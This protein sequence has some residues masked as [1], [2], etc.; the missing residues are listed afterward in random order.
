MTHVTIQRF[1]EAPIPTQYGLLRTVVFREETPEGA[2]ENLALVFGEIDGASEVLT[3]VH[4]ECLTGEVMRSLKCDCGEQLDVALRSIAEAGRG[5]VLYLRQEGRG[6]GLGNKIRAYAL[7]E[8]RGLDT[9]EANRAL[10]F[11]DDLRDYSVAARMLESLGVRSI[12]LMTNN[13]AKADVLARENINIVRRV[14]MV[15]TTNLH[16]RNYLRTKNRRM[17]HVIPEETKIATQIFCRQPSLDE[18]AALASIGATHLAWC[19]EPND[20]ASLQLSFQIIEQVRAAR[21]VSTIMIMSSDVETIV[22]ITRM[23]QPNL[24][25]IPAE[26]IGRGIV[27]NDLPRLADRLAPQTRLMM[28]IPVRLAGSLTNIDS[29]AIAARYQHFADCLILDTA[30]D[31]DGESCGCTGKTNDWDLCRE[32]VESSRIPVMLAGGL[33]PDNVAAAMHSVRPWGVDACSSLETSPGGS[34]DLV[35]SQQFIQRANEA[36][37][38]IAKIDIRSPEPLPS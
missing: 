10:G 3:R 7:Q 1:T 13:P 14:P 36:H 8:S 24:I 20:A 19:V 33:S 25:L 4:S 9:V 27:E 35:A 32:I 17:G 22:P 16:N 29:R 2:R 26:R 21:V 30:L 28:S 38:T 18:M 31:P 6:I 11:A 37:A 12:A 5:V 23:L 15:V 34:K